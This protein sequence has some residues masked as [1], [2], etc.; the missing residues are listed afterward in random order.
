MAFV[1]ARPKASSSITSAVERAAHPVDVEQQERLHSNAEV[2]S[3]SQTH[4]RLLSRCGQG[5]GE[6]SGT[7]WPTVEWAGSGNVE[8]V[9]AALQAIPR[10]L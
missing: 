9:F 7:E 5:S 3:E 1:V 4:T 6:A 8:A 10:A 2:G